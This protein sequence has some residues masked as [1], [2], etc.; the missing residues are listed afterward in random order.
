MDLQTVLRLELLKRHERNSFNVADRDVLVGLQKLG[1]L[2]QS[3]AASC[4]ERVGGEG[5][6]GGEGR[7]GPATGQHE[8]RVGQTKAGHVG[9]LG[10]SRVDGVVALPAKVEAERQLVKVLFQTARDTSTKTSISVKSDNVPGNELLQCLPRVLNDV[11]VDGGRLT[12][13]E[14]S[15][16]C[17]NGGRRESDEPTRPC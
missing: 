3:T 6:V 10:D 9:G 1:E 11:A 14:R 17:N 13:V 12:G 5:L 2:G 15:V 16:D 4:A 8:R 7:V